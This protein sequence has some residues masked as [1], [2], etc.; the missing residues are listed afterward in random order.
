MS[1]QQMN[2]ASEKKVAVWLEKIIRAD[3][4]YEIIKNKEEINIINKN[5][6]QPHIPSFSFDRLSRVANLTAA[7]NVLDSLKDLEIISIDNSVS[8]KTGEILRPDLVCFNREKRV[9]V[10]F[11]IKRDKQTERQALTELYAYEQ[12]IRN[13]LP[14]IGNREIQTVLISKDW[15]TLLEHAV[16]NYNSWGNKSCLALSIDQITKDDFE[17]AIKIPNDWYF[18]GVCGLPDECFETFDL[19]INGEFEENEFVPLKVATLMNIII[20]N[21]DRNDIHGFLL[22]WKDYSSKNYGN[23]VITFCSIDPLA[24]FKS[25]NNN[26]VKY[27]KSGLTKYVEEFYNDNY[28]RVSSSLEK[29]VSNN[30]H[31]LK[32]EYTVNFSNYMNWKMKTNVIK[33]HAK[34]VYYDFYDFYG[35]IGDYVVDF[36]SNSVVRSRYLPF[37]NHNSVDWHHQLIAPLLIDNLTNNTPYPEGIIRC[38]DS[39]ILGSKLGIYHYLV[40]CY[41]AKPNENL[42]ISVGWAYSDMMNYIVENNQFYM[43]FSTIQQ[44]PP[45]LSNIDENRLATLEEYYEWIISHLLND[46]QGIHREIFKIA[47]EASAA[48]SGYFEPKIAEY[49]FS[50]PDFLHPVARS[51]K[52]FLKVAVNHIYETNLHISK[53]FNKIDLFSKI[54]LNKNNTIEENAVLVDSLDDREIIDLFTRDSF[55]SFDKIYTGVFHSSTLDWAFPI[56]IDDARKNIKQL[57]LNGDYPAVS[58]TQNGHFGIVLLDT[59]ENEGIKLLFKNIDIDTETLFVAGS[60]AAI[61][62]VKMTWVELKTKFEVH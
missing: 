8:L 32:E 44:P 61:T 43:V 26:S 17:V 59:S 5:V 31:I 16:S 42:K 62:Y 50:Q 56:D 57:Y 41:Q 54:K 53:D 24:V 38:K 25:C 23:W 13:I 36:V 49:F 18:R 19:F 33:Y 52:N 22:V 28:S 1:Q 3:K 2:F 29:V 14:F 6:N 45:L 30:L 4:L 27:R 12:E 60:A 21:C 39:F 37:L 7:D 11:E 55:T 48:I 34:P 47:F 40:Q 46:G 10:I 58:V 35:L 15:D 9:F 51:L 20:K